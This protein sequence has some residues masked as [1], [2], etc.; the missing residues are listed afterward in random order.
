MCVSS[1]SKIASSI[2]F[3]DVGL[4]ITELRES[5][6]DLMLARLTKIDGIDLPVLSFIN[7]A[8]TAAS[9]LSPK[10][11]LSSAS[12]CVSK[13]VTSTLAG[14]RDRTAWLIRM[15]IASWCSGVA[16]SSESN[17]SKEDKRDSISR[18]VSTRL[19]G[20]IR[21]DAP[22]LRASAI[23]L[24]IWDSRVLYPSMLATEARSTRSENALSMSLFGLIPKISR[25][26]S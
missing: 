5:N 17:P 6:A 20:T 25:I 16:S 24:S 15:S 11:P 13:I 23:D 7:T 18:S 21:R 12:F 26:A 2:P 4:S 22:L 3:A 1:S 8:M 14:T 9:G 19:T 10:I